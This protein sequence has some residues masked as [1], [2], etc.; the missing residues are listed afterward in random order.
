MNGDKEHL[1]YLDDYLV[2]SPKQ[3]S[4]GSVSLT[5]QSVQK[6]SVVLFT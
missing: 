6:N 3:K 1:N 2:E 4:Q 5:S